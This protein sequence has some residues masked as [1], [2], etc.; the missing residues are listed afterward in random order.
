M[1]HLLLVVP[2]NVKMYVGMYDI[3]YVHPW[4][5]AREM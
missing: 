5:S 1:L 4:A 3:C 2:Y